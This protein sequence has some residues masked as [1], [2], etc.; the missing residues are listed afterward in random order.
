MT[1]NGSPENGGNWT[2][3]LVDRTGDEMGAE[4]PTLS[5]EHAHY[6][7]GLD[8]RLSFAWNANDIIENALSIAIHMKE[9]GALLFTRGPGGKLSKL[10]ISRDKVKNGDREIK[11]RWLIIREMNVDETMILIA[12]HAKF[13]GRRDDIP[14]PSEIVQAVRYAEPSGFWPQLDGFSCTQ[15]MREDRTIADRSGYDEDSQ[16]FLYNLP[17]MEAIPEHCTLDDAKAALGDLEQL[18][19]HWDYS[20]GTNNGT[21]ETDEDRAEKQRVNLAAAIC[22]AATGILYAG[23]SCPPMFIVNAPRSGSGKTYLVNCAYFLSL[24]RIPIPLNYDRGSDEFHK[25]LDIAVMEAGD[26]VI[27]NVNGAVGDERLDTWIT[28]DTLKPR[29]LGK[30]TEVIIKNIAV[31]SANG[32]NI[33]PRADFVRR[34]VYIELN[35]N[36]ESAASRT[37]DADPL[38][39]IK[40][41]R[42]KYVRALLI[43][44]RAYEQY[45]ASG[46][47]KATTKEFAGFDDWVRCVVE[48]LTWAGISNPLGN[49]SDMQ[50]ADPV[51]EERT[52]RVFALIHAIE[53]GIIPPSFNAKDICKVCERAWEENSPHSE[54]CENVKLAFS[55]NKGYAPGSVKYML[56]SL[57]GVIQSGHVVQ[58]THQGNKKSASEY[59]INRHLDGIDAFSDGIERRAGAVM[60]IDARATAHK[61]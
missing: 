61:F 13:R 31:K 42:G 20:D 59:I 53:C 16:M 45:L 28:S 58:V 38:A 24:G 33:T 37:F 54:I 56:K 46:G 32:N 12:K 23:Q 26:Q 1:S 2:P 21:S 27:D 15:F 29:I 25:R 40:A 44:G 4:R 17:H 55:S 11:I 6:L 39:M 34:C 41:D 5:E 18:F 47:K 50:Q 49:L 9:R 22:F 10:L 3:R 51:A 43:I 35:A 60:K 19:G 52:A 30:S 7:E 8:R 57:T 36:F 14:P 48:P